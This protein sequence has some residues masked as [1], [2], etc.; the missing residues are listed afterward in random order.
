MKILVINS[1]SS[2]LKYQLISMTHEKVLAKGLCDRIGIGQSFLKHKKDGCDT[3]VI[4]RDMYNHKVAIKEVIKVLSDKKLGVISDMDEIMAVG[5]RV[6]HGGEKFKESVIIDNTVMKTINNCIKLA[7]L[8]NPANITGIEACIEIMPKKPMVAVFD[9]AFHQTMP[10][11]AFLYAVPYEAYEKYAIRKYGFHGTSHMYVSQRA[12]AMLNKPISEL[13]LISCHLGNGASVCAIQGGKSVETSM[14]F[15]PLAGLPMGTRC[16][17][18]DPAVVLFLM[19][20]EKMSINEVNKCLNKRSGVLGI[21]GV[22]SDFRDIEA[23]AEEGNE[24]ARLAIDIFSYNV[25]K[26]IGEY[27][28][29]LNGLDAVIFTAGIG[30]NN[31][32]VRKKILDGLAYMGIT[33]DWDK[34]ELRGSEVDISSEDSK[35]RTLV[36][37]TNEELAIAR[38]T[39]NLV[40]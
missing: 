29:V 9:T 19:E 12:A 33:V 20:N 36:I 11:H 16:G 10:K 32:L 28:S 8:H 17:T 34:N 15:T 18:I 6:V 37:P 24:R 35:V 25:K 7:P 23:A 1:G 5:H 21:S 31:P 26:Y 14:G 27:A 3:V 30:E 13:K 39:L 2:S 4:D 40:K 38:E 22:S